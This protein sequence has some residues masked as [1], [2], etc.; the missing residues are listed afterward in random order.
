MMGMAIVAAG[1]VAVA[2][3]VAVAM[4]VLVIRSAAVIVAAGLR[5][6]VGHKLQLARKVRVPHLGNARPL[7]AC[8]HP[9]PIVVR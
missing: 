2:M 1:P 5:G 4:I 6:L 3:A 7:L 9:Q 8:E